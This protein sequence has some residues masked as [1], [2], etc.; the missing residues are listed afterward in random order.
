[1][2]TGRRGIDEPGEGSGGLVTQGGRRKKGREGG[3][4]REEGR[5]RRNDDDDDGSRAGVATTGRAAGSRC[6]NQGVEET[7]TLFDTIVCGRRG[8]DGATREGWRVGGR[9]G[10]RV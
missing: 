9:G 7:A 8:G 6:G 2:G 4:A 10:G 1:M 5:Q 3:S